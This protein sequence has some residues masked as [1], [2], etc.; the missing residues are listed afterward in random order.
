MRCV[1]CGWA[2]RDDACP[3]GASRPGAAAAVA[4]N[5]PVAARPGRGPSLMFW[6]P[7][8]VVQRQGALYKVR[9]RSLDFWC[10]AYDLVPEAPERTRLLRDGTRVWALWLDGRWYP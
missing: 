5:T 6:S 1:Q 3:C 2:V 4:V 9:T 7:G 8:E 10:D